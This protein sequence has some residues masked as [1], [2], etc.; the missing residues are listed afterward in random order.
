MYGD[1]GRIALLRP[2]V[3]PSTE[4]DFHTHLPEG[5]ALS[6]WGVEYD[7]ATLEGLQK[8]SER[9]RICA[10]QYKGF[11]I[12]I[13]VFACTTG[14]MIGGPG[15]DKKLI[16]QMETASGIPALTTTTALLDAF[17]T[18]G[19]RK[20]SIVTPY[21]ES[22]NAMEKAFLASEGIE[23]AAIS[24]LD[25]EFDIPFTRPEEMQELALRQGV[26]GAD[27]VFLSCTGICAIPAIEPL[28]ETL[29]V[30]VLSSNQATI[31]SA[32]RRIGYKETLPGLGMLGRN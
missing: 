5:Y 17:E 11:P 4:M 19:I 1:K 18:L 7:G 25:R 27:A 14:S 16:G 24:G 22:L 28:E 3:T 9:V 21:T 31:W 10:E 23:T 12:D 15:Y 26:C 6:T 2:G 8:M 29:G 30:P 32:L 20:L 13:M